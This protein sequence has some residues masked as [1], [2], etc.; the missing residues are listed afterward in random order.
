MKEIRF[1]KG[2]T[3]ENTDSKQLKDK[4]IRSGF[5]AALSFSV[6]KVLQ[7][8][9]S[10]IVARILAPE[11]YGMNGIIWA[12]IL[13]MER[14]TQMGMQP[15]AV[16][17]A[18]YDT[19]NMNNVLDTL[20]VTNVF[21]GGVLCIAMYFSGHWIAVF[22]EKP[23][24]E[25]LIQFGSIYFLF[26][27]F[28]NVGL[29]IRMRNIDFKKLEIWQQTASCVQLIVMIGLAMKLRNVWALVYGSVIGSALF[30]ISTYF[31]SPYK[32]KWRFSKVIFLDLFSFGK[33][34][35][36]TEIL[37]LLA[38]RVD[39]IVLGKV[40]GMIELGFYVLAYRIVCLNMIQ[41]TNVIYKITFPAFASIQDNTEM[42]IR[43]FM[44]SL[45][46]FLAIVLPVLAFLYIF[47][48][49][50]VFV[51]YG[52][53]WMPVVPV[54]KIIIFVAAFKSLEN[55]FK[56]IFQGTGH[57]NKLFKVHLV[58]TIF[59]LLSIY[60][61]SKFYGILGAAY[62]LLV[63]TMLFNSISW[64]LFF[65]L[66]ETRY[67]FAVRQIFPSIAATGIMVGILSLL[68]E[69]SFMTFASL[70]YEIV[71]NLIIAVLAYVTFFF[72]FGKINNLAS[73]A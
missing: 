13:I 40:K 5:W 45:R 24:L 29:T 32:P 60:P 34:F 50:I 71:V 58:C 7:I 67:R 1:H 41:M 25:P 6:N 22:Y 70:P 56:S 4:I 36:L 23:L 26:N 37:I 8:I 62:L 11:D 31:V 20:F 53:K 3:L 33:Y 54:L 49:D 38:S 10:I 14:F 55:L 21:R 57:I 48:S 18:E 64:P 72:G 12:V 59:F 63:S 51:L 35:I 28:V 42:V 15:A 66:F 68:N 47:A 46:Y 69:Y 52:E 61:V 19:N 65:K 27:S 73:H 17:K 2:R 43:I 30:T 39:A 44:K 16:Q 9:T